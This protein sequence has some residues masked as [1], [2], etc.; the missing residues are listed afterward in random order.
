MV[1]EE[2]R[3]LVQLRQTQ[4]DIEAALTQRHNLNTCIVSTI[5]SIGTSD[6][7]DDSQSICLPPSFNEDAST[8]TMRGPSQLPVPRTSSQAHLQAFATLPS[9]ITQDD[10]CETNT[11]NSLDK[12]QCVNF[13]LASSL[14]IVPDGAENSLSLLHIYF[15]EESKRLWSMDML[16]EHNPHYIKSRDLLIELHSKLD[17]QLQTEMLEFHAKRD[18]PDLKKLFNQYVMETAEK[19]FDVRELVD[20]LE[21]VLLRIILAISPL[22][23]SLLLDSI[24][25]S[26][27]T[28][29]LIKDKDVIILLSS[30]G[31]GK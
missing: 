28:A 12:R 7:S 8:S 3:E 10:Y 21:Q 26:C 13:S 18:L 23:V 9:P 11:I 20:K 31:V 27:M 5:D 16:A 24:R 17:G 30:T 25:G 4:S 1:A 15:K 22:D 29:N 19:R 14:G 2:E 6:V